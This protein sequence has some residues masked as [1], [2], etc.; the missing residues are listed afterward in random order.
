MLPI[1]HHK[2]DGIG[3]PR[4]GNKKASSILLSLRLLLALGQSNCHAV[5]TGKQ[6]VETP[7]LRGTEA[8]W[9]QPAATHQ[10]CHMRQ[11]EVNPQPQSSLH[12]LAAP[13]ELC[14]LTRYPEAE[15]FKFPRTRDRISETKIMFT[16]VFEL[17]GCE[18]ICHTAINY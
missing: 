5:G 2:T 6:S 13:S 10:P 18:V 9:Q 11:F 12:M 8:S 17:L 16:I 4:P 14:N 1:G 15:P 3:L 7:S